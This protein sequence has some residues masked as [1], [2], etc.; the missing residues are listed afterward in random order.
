MKF[1]RIPDRIKQTIKELEVSL[2]KEAKGISFVKGND[3]EK[4]NEDP[5]M[6]FLEN[7]DQYA[8]ETGITDLAENHDHYLYGLP[9]KS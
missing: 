6:E 8:V 1:Q 5:W 7:I 2:P 4:L 3:K 9:K